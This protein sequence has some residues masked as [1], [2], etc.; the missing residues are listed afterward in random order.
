MD[1][2][3]KVAVA[4]GTWILLGSISVSLS[5]FV[6]WL[7]I[8]WL[9]GV[10]SVG[11]ASATV[12]SSTIAV[13]LVGAGLNI[14]VM[15]EVAA[16]GLR[17]FIAALVLSSIVGLVAGILAVPLIQALGYGDLALIASLLAIATAISVAVL[18]SLIGFER[19]KDYFQATLIGSVS[20][21]VVGIVFAI[22]GFKF[23]APLIGY[24]AYPV[25]ASLV[26]SAFLASTI[27]LKDVRLGGKDLKNMAMLA[28]S[29]YPYMF[30]N[31]LL[32]M[33]G[34]Y[35]FAYLVRE[36]IPTGILYIALMIMLSIA[37]VPG[38][39]LSAALPIGTRRNTNP[40]AESFRIG[41]ALATP[42]IVAVATASTLILK[43]VNPELVQGA[44]T[45]RILLLSI[46]PLTALTTAITKLNKE[47]QTKSIAVIGVARLVLLIALLPPLTGMLGIQG[48]ALAFLTTNILLIPLVLRIE[49]VIAKSLLALWGIHLALALLFYIAPLSELVKAVGA[50]VL[51]PM[52][53]HVTNTFT[54]NEFYSTLKVIVNTLYHR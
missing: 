36:A 13:T 18:S 35:V 47:G 10:E 26:A 8:T 20:K 24:L 28:L 29:N 49:P 32:T 12:S 23:L 16:R 22:L 9:V 41:L 52:L 43:A 38:S 51:A 5:G 37:M 45:L 44:D 50:L 21:L 27:N 48:A 40:F 31:Q 17:A 1:R 54:L 33:L 2:H 11:V 14:A 30:S 34:V 6:F 19:F 39:I 42:I 46:A 3:V 7:V 25:T 53:M 4:G 15:R